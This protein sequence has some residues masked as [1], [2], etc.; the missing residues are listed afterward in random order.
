MSDKPI[1][2]N[3]EGGISARAARAR[4]VAA[5]EHGD[6]EHG[7]SYQAENQVLLTPEAVRKLIMSDDGIT[8]YTQL[9]SQEELTEGP[10]PEREMMVESLAAH[11]KELFPIF[12]S[13]VKDIVREGR[14]ITTG[15]APRW[16]A[17]NAEIPRIVDLF[18]RGYLPHPFHAGGYALSFQ[19]PSRRTFLLVVHPDPNEPTKMALDVLV[20]MRESIGSGW[21]TYF[22]L[23]INGHISFEGKI[24]ITANMDL[25]G[26]L[27]EERALDIIETHS[28]HL[29]FALMMMNT[30]WVTTEKLQVSDKLNNARRKSGKEPLPDMLNVLGAE[31]VT[32]I[33]GMH[34]AGSRDEPVGTHASPVAHLRRAHIRRLPLRDVMVRET[35]V[36][37]RADGPV[38]NNRSHYVIRPVK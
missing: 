12:A 34:R 37:M 18:R 36:N 1:E 14:L 10:E 24:H 31:Y 27:S 20:A 30:K 3:D 38:D 6:D 32:V 4:A 8:V 7:S 35:R 9:E 23:V 13:H 16:E 29:L 17:L 5:I 26:R 2:W 15:M 25:V 22:E 11:A 21:E 33:N 28:T 19:H